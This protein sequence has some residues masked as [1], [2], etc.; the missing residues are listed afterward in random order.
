MPCKQ[1]MK[2]QERQLY[3]DKHR[4]DVNLYEGIADPV[5]ILKIMHTNLEYDPMIRYTPYKQNKEQLYMSLS[6]EDAGKMLDYAV[7]LLV[8]GDE[9]TSKDILLSLVCYKN[10][11]LSAWIPEL[12]SRELYYPGILFKDASEEVRNQLMDQVEYD[13]DNRNH[14][15]SAL[16]WIGDEQ[17]V[18]RLHEWRKSSPEWVGNL[19]ISPDLYT[20]EAGWEL[21]EEGE[22][23]NLFYGYSYAIEK[24]EKAE[25]SVHGA[26]ESV[27]LLT[28]SSHTCLWCG[29]KLTTLLDIGVSHPF[30]EFLSLAGERLKVETCVICGCYGTVYMDVDLNGETKWST[31]NKRPDYLPDINHDDYDDQYLSASKSFRIASQPRSVYHAAE[32]TLEP[33]VSQ[34]GGHP[35]WIQDAEYPACPCCSKRMTFISQLDWGEIEKH[36]EGIYYM[37]LCPNSMITATLFQQS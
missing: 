27:I 9:D 25:E 4:R 1:E 7:N 34:V 26:S 29:G 24:V 36:G 21:T 3:I 15:L 31:Y 37:F 20:Y 23:H 18:Q 16:V 19:N 30:F 8:S 2:R 35:S 22:R 14:L 6:A 5:E 13:N 12:I 17:V 33:T 28:E 11:S 32:W 10:I